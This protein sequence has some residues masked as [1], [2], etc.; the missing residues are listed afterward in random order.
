M[1]PAITLKV[2]AE[3]P[4]C[5]RS[6][7]DECRGSDEIVPARSPGQEP[8]RCWSDPADHGAI[9]SGWDVRG[10]SERR[11]REHHHHRQPDGRIA[12]DPH[13]QRRGRGRASGRKLLPGIWFYDPGF[14]ATAACESSIT[15]SRRRRRDPA[16]PGLPDRA[17]GRALDLPRGGLPAPPRR[18]AHGGAVR[19]VASRDHATTP[20][21]TR[22]CASGSSRASTTT[23]IPWACSSRRSPRCRPSTSTPRTSSTPSPAT[24]RSS[25]SS[26]RCPPWPPPPT[27]SAWA[28]PSSTPTTRS[29][30]PRTSCR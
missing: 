23:P 6:R 20:S 29:T 18:A 4:S 10:G 8:V 14:I 22:T 17:A 12:R 2:E 11:G 16:L 28:C 5:P 7:S 21:S 9:G 30:S 19:R 26:P 13:P 27:A 15:V 24:S 1:S 3:P 25:G